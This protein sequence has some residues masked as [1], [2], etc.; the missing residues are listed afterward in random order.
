MHNPNILA[1]EIKYPWYRHRPWPKKF[2]H[3]GR[4][5]RFI[6][7]HRMTDAQRKGTDS[8]W[9]CGYRDTFISIW[10]KD[11]EKDGSDDSCGWS[12]P[13][14][15]NR[16]K[17]ALWNAAWGE[18]QN[19]HFLCVEGKEW[20]G[21]YTEAVSLYSGLVLL[22]ARVLR[23]EITSDKV[24]NSAIA[25]IHHVDCVPATGLFCF[26]PG[27]HTNSQKDSPED[28]QEHFYGILCG[29]ARELLRSN[30][31]WWK[32]PRW[33]FWHWRFQIHPWQSFKRAFIDR[34]YK[35]GRGFKWGESCIS[36]WH[37]T[38]IWHNH[39]DDSAK[40]VTHTPTNPPAASVG[41]G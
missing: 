1:F 9:D 34:C 40:P 41:E 27:Y 4:E 16:Q 23:I 39:C 22:V 15:T 37:G 2:R 12:Y 11:P 28:R 10:H 21:T 5:K 32:H 30:R 38:K 25:T 17:D 6:Y 20:E 8:Y 3:R 13:K 14:L 31:P 29:V 36:D 19:P 33:H 35:C 24:H 7:E 18:G 26:L